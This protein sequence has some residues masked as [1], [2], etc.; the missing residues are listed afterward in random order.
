M[1]KPKGKSKSP[2]KRT[3]KSPKS[4]GSPKKEKKDKSKK[5]KKGKKP[6]VAPEE[7]SEIE[8]KQIY[9]T[10]V[11]GTSFFVHLCVCILCIFFPFL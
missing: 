3:P 7:A 11:L 8:G 6:K 4:P 2:G 1:P 9:M 10:F 5:G